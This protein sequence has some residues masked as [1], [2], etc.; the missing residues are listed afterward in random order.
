MGCNVNFF[1]NN[2]LAIILWCINLLSVILIFQIVFDIIPKIEVGF[3]IEKAEKINTFVL[4]CSIAVVTST[5]FYLLL[6][7]IPEKRKAVSARINIQLDLQYLSENM[8]MLILYVAKKYSL[9]VKDED[10]L[11][12]NISYDEFGKVEI[13]LFENPIDIYSVYVRTQTGSAIISEKTKDFN[14]KTKENIVNL[15]ANKILSRPIM[16]FEDVDLVNLLSEIEKCSLRELY[17]IYVMKS[18]IYEE[19][20]DRMLNEKLYSAL[21]E[22]YKLYQRTLQFVS[23]KCYYIK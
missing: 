16:I 10:F 7:Y 23:P 21:V 22:Y 4:D 1:R 14:F 3:S 6:V 19:T 13:S 2:R 11:Y 17:F 8:Q 20:L 12:K 18:S 5:L 9:E 15:F